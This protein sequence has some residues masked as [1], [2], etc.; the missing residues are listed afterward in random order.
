M[1]TDLD[2]RESRVRTLLLAGTAL[3]VLVILVNLVLVLLKE[4]SDILA[5]A[6]ARAQNLVQLI[7]EQ[8]AGSLAAVEVAL[9]GTATTT[10]LVPRDGRTRTADIHELLL[11]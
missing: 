5:N 2:S 11:N 9:A 7:E 4:R 6:Q 8:T 1:S 10:Q 3:L